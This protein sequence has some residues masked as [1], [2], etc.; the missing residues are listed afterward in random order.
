MT[1][2]SLIAVAAAGFAAMAFPSIT[3]VANRAPSTVPVIMR[4]ILMSV[5]MT[6][7]SCLMTVP[8]FRTWGSICAPYLWNRPICLLASVYK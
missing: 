1:R 4:A 5:L 3:V 2:N 8:F 7:L 6:S